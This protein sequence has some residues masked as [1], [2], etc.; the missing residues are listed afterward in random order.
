MFKKVI[1]GSL[2]LGLLASVAFANNNVKNVNN[3][4]KAAKYVFSYYINTSNSFKT[5]TDYKNFAKAFN[6]LFETTKPKQV[7]TIT[8]L[9]YNKMEGKAIV[10]KKIIKGDKKALKKIYN[11]VLYHFCSFQNIR[12]VVAEF[13]EYLAYNNASKICSIFTKS[14][15]F[16]HGGKYISEVDDKIA[17]KDF[18]VV[19]SS[20]QDCKKVF[21]KASK[22]ANELEQLIKK[23]SQKQQH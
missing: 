16:D 19:V 8:W 2:G 4:I 21:N 3:N 1:L 14:G 12:P 9:A 17:G 18:K 11:K 22:I 6:T 20:R 5:N 7:D 13:S 23:H 15:F 10:T